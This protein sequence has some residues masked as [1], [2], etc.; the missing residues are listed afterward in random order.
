M[1]AAVE[2]SEKDTRHQAEEEGT[3]TAAQQPKKQS[4]THLIRMLSYLNATNARFRKWCSSPAPLKPMI[5]ISEFDR[6]EKS[7][8]RHGRTTQNERLRMPMDL[9]MGV[10]A[11]LPPAT[12]PQVE[13]TGHYKAPSESGDGVKFQELFP[14]GSGPGGAEAIRKVMRCCGLTLFLV[15]E[16]EYVMYP[17]HFTHPWKADDVDPK[18][19]DKWVAEAVKDREEYLTSRKKPIK[20]VRR[21]AP[22]RGYHLA[23]R[24][25]GHYDSEAEEDSNSSARSLVGIRSRSDSPEFLPALDPSVVNELDASKYDSTSDDGSEYQQV[26]HS[27]DPSVMNEI[28]ASKYDSSSDD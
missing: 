11:F 15:L 19:V 2:T 1:S 16:N 13:V 18:V 28:D 22:P 9:M 14:I 5:E 27:F 20:K 7:L 3:V 4:K 21:N 23:L 24:R 17:E 6:V 25:K 8:K 26:P 12:F 10:L